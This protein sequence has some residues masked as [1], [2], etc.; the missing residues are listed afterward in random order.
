MTGLLD[1]LNLKPQERRLVVIVA[2][3]V[4]LV[5][6]FW[7]IFPVFGE[8]GKAQ[9]RIKDERNLLVNYEMEVNK[10]PIYER[11]LNELRGAGN[12]IPSEQQ[13]GD[14]MRD[15]QNQA[16]ATRVNVT[17]YDFRDRTATF[18]T[19]AFFDEKSLIVNVVSTGEKE[20]IDFLFR[21]SSH[22]MPTRV[23]QINLS[24]DPPQQK[25]G[26]S[27]TFVRSYQRKPTPRSASSTTTAP[28]P[29]TATTNNN[30]EPEAESPPDAAP[31]TTSPPP[32]GR[33]TLPNR[34]PPATSGATAPPQEAPSAPPMEQPT[35]KR[36][37]PRRTPPAAA[38]P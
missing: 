1:K 18:E 15:V 3:V 17:R 38:N 21:I 30:P 11:Q 26:G 22:E 34:T 14:L 9:Q 5:L 2:I 27:I 36:E 33:S 8:L 31:T 12:Y 16:R 23:R 28:P 7:F 37:L 29:A 10:A 13:G 6:N 4:F 32:S 20:L 24:P 35:L 25:L 19:N